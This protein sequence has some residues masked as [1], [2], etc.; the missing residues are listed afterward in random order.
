VLEGGDLCLERALLGPAICL[1]FLTTRL[2][3]MLLG[4]SA[5]SIAAFFHILNK[6]KYRVSISKTT[7][8]RYAANCLEFHSLPRGGGTET[9]QTL[10]GEQSKV[11]ESQ[12]HLQWN[13]W[14]II[15]KTTPQWKVEEMANLRNQ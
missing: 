15:L 6:P 1:L 7:S 10:M 3:G 9:T 2:K 4:S 12:L 5:D 8:S 14:P 11:G 13:A